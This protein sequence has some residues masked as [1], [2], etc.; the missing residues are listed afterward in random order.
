[1]KVLLAPLHFRQRFCRHCR[2]IFEAKHPDKWLG[3][4]EFERLP[5]LGAFEP[6]TG[7][8]PDLPSLL[9]FDEF[10]LDAEAEVILRSPG[11]RRWL[12]QWPELLEA[13][14]SEGAVSVV[15]VW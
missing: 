11:K 15:D 6:A 4:W 3:I 10:A 1:M 14:R 13:L 2:R 12:G 7:F 5:P 8:R 9:M